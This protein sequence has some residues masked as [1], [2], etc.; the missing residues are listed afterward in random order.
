MLDLSQYYSQFKTIFNI[1][2]QKK[3]FDTISNA[4]RVKKF[5]CDIDI[6][7]SKTSLECLFAFIY[8]H[9]DINNKSEI[10]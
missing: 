2:V 6:W 3:T 7:E 4:N 9:K 10:L 8:L 5:C 1:Y